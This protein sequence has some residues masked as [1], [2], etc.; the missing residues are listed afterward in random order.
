MSHAPRL[1]LALLALAAASRADVIRVPQDYAHLQV[2]VNNAA[3]GDLILVQPGTWPDPLD[4]GSKSLVIVADGGTVTLPQVRIHDLAAGQVVVLD[5]I[6]ALGSKS[7]FPLG[8]WQ[9]ALVVTDCAGRVVVQDGSFT[10]YVGAN[11]MN[12]SGTPLFHPAGWDAVRIDQA[13]SVSLT[14]CSLT[15][16]AGAVVNNE[17]TEWGAGSGGAGLR[18]IGADVA[19]HVATL[20]GGTGGSID[21]TIG[22]GAGHGGA[23]AR[24][25][26]GTLHA[27]G[28]SFTGMSGGS[29]DCS[30][31]SCGSGGDGGDGARVD[32]DP[33]TPAALWHGDCTFDG[34]HGGS[35]GL[36]S[37]GGAS[38][39]ADG[40][41]G[42]LI[43]LSGPGASAQ[44]LHATL[45]T[46]EAA[47]PVREGQSVSIEVVA[48]PGELVFAWVSPEPD[49][50]LL[51]QLA[52][53]A[54]VDRF[55]PGA[56]ALALGPV[57]PAG[58]LSVSY[59][60]P[61]LGPGV[62]AHSLY[63]QGVCIAPERST[64]T[65]STVVN[66]LDAGF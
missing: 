15:G 45:R 60:V 22:S 63:I 21:D 4:I 10:G 28:S 9:E 14:R 7:A 30:F 17:E 34:A 54:L 39:G 31:F 29:G 11:H 35:G 33:A 37:T 23:G 50:V 53:V 16:G 8:P 43:D 18:S 27:A 65:T 59:T 19:V 40:V 49:W 48:A 55:A 46:L 41:D 64:L 42:K 24:L 38:P 36:V 2:A 13:G 26:D 1:A 6:S 5:G 44:L 12:L 57:P 62:A 25:A 32:G 66:L 20:Q 52:G 56:L 51:P 61:Q 47:S 58:P 3:E